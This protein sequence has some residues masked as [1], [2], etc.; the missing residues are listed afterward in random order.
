M[1]AKANR[2]RKEG[3]AAVRGR[4]VFPVGGLALKK[5]LVPIDFSP[6]S[7]KALLYAMPLAAEFHAEILLLHVM[8]VFYPPP[9]LAMVDSPLLEEKAIAEARN[10]LAAWGRQIAGVAV[11]TSIQRGNPYLAIVDAAR[12]SRTD[13]IVVGNRGRSGLEHF[14]LGSTAERV[15]RHASC[16]VLVVREVE[17]DF[18][19]PVAA[20]KP[21]SAR[22]RP[23]REKATR[24]K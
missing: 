24:K 1:K 15:V 22:R 13:L 21:E 11:T 6:A 2:R 3:P 7:R 19:N 8:E 14:L 16:P 12:S 20:T 10:E 4:H 23:K 17:H 5:I 9:E 18:L